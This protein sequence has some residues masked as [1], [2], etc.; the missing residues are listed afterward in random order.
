MTVPSPFVFPT[1][2]IL[3]GWWKQLAPLQ[4]RSLWA[5]HLLLHRIEALVG[6]QQDTRLEPFPQFVLKALTLTP[7]ETLERLDQRFHVGRP[8]LLQVLREL[9]AV[10]LVQRGPAGTWS[11]TTLGRQGAEH[12]A[13]P[14]PGHER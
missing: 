5:G 9:E 11:L 4:P 12:G 3:A 8:V 7:Q 13:Y 10:Q 1:S 14:R 2:R 6:L